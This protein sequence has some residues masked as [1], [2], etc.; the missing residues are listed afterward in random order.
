MKSKPHV[1]LTRF[2]IV[3][4]ILLLASLPAIVYSAPQSPSEQGRVL[5]LMEG[6]TGPHSLGVDRGSPGLWQRLLKLRTTAS[7]L[8]TTAHPDDEQGGTLAY[9]S[10]GQGVRTAL[11]TLNRGEAGANAIGPELFDGLG[12]I[13][14][15][16]LLLAG[17]YYGLDD[18]Y[19]TTMID[20]GFSKALQEA[21][22]QWG[23]KNVL[24]DVVRVIRI[25]RPLV[26]ISRFHGSERDGHGNH[27]TAGVISQEAFDAAGDP[28]RFPEQLSREGL[29][30]WQPLKMYRSNLRPRRFSGGDATPP[31]QPWHLRLN[32]GLFSPWIGQSY[33]D[34]SALGLS[35]Q[36]SQNA[37][38][39]RPSRGVFY[40][41][42]ERLKSKIGGPARESGFFDGM[43]TSVAGLYKLLG[44]K[45]PDEVVPVLSSI[46]THVGQAVAAFN[47]ENPAAVVP[48]LT[49][50]LKETRQALSLSV[51]HP[52]AVFMLRI[53]ERQFMDAINTALG[54]EL[55]AVAVPAGTHTDGSPWGR[56][57]TMGVVVP[58]QRFQVGTVLTNPSPL[59]I[60]ALGIQLGGSARWLVD[61]V[62]QVSQQLGEGQAMGLSF[63]VKA[64]QDAE[65]S[66]RYFYRDSIQ[67]T[68]YEMRDARY[69]HLPGRK[70]ALV[71]QATYE[72]DG[73]NVQVERVVSTREADLPYGY[74]LR[75]LKLAPALSVRVRPGSLIVPLGSKLRVLPIQVEL[76]N[77]REGGS[78]G[79]LVLE[80]PSGWQVK[81]PEQAFSFA[82]A[83]ERRNFSFSVSLPRIQAETYKIEA[84]ATAGGRE[85]R[86]G[87]DVIRHR[88]DDIRYL[89]R[90]AVADVRGV[91]VKIRGGLKV[92]YVMGVGDEV[93][94]GIEQL[95]AAVHLLSAG[96]LASGDL[97]RYDDIV[98]GT[99]AYAVRS[100]LITYNQR[101]LDY[102][103]KGGNLIVLYQ[104]Q[105]FV[106]DKW[107][108]YPAQ[109]PPRAEEVSEEDSP[110]RILAPDHPVF[111]R[112][113]KIT[114]ADFRNWVEQRGSKFFSQWDPAYT[115][116]IETWDRNQ[117]PQPGGWLTAKYGDGYYTYFAYAV[118]RQLPYGVSGA[119]RIFANLLSLTG[120]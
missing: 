51:G 48:F 84:V 95:G 29:R 93:P 34:F 57:P 31:T 16:E 117:K 40:S 27:Q 9:L 87:Y 109:L 12:L 92:G 68:R 119:Y 80:V 60:R 86:E 36:R 28:T 39:R 14:T 21:L 5:T 33:Q 88:D 55:R 63:R 111:N 96:D 65:P 70:P 118:H 110:V 50:G 74:Q 46:Q 100:D 72:I 23:K 35:F 11:L 1:S 69:R 77:N 99:R 64:P 19:F 18:Q 108:A 56:E 59:G 71:A 17:R 112:P 45:A 82:Q 102:A 79:T 89:Y 43:D 94:A 54:L 10:R 7:A 41:F 13:R 32:V 114:T 24:E 103:R 8:Y 37:G 47:L 105:E 3:S 53:K 116:M 120:R 42:F 22:D 91:D 78:E 25:N 83:S 97:D 44:E 30:V 26:I 106:P 98:I 62:P 6:K 104:T 67:Q 115:A 81:P 107:A 52:D 4:M 75:E 61:P 20:Y 49:L 58:G 85:Y 15:E 73:Q 101:L 113:N 90:D 38:R 2:F 76:L 66:R